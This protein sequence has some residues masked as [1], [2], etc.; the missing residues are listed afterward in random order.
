[1]RFN[2]IVIGIVLG[3]LSLCVIIP[4]RSIPSVP[5]ATFGPNLFPTLIGMGIGLIAIKILIDG[6][7]TKEKIPFCDISDWFGQRKGFLAAVWAVGGIVIGIVFFQQLGFVL[8]SLAY[9]IP[10]MLMMGAHPVISV[11]VAAS[12]SLGAF[13]LFSRVLFVPLPVGLLT[14]LG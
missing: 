14:F 13:F 5:G 11:T 6:V 2:D 12:A 9:A 10:L 8:F 3:I 1:M 7:R 4:A